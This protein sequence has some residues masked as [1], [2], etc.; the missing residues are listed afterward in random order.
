MKYVMINNCFP[1]IFHESVQ[2]ELMKRLEHDNFKITSAG[3][4][5]E[6]TLECFG[7]S[8]LKIGIAELDT[9]FVKKLLGVK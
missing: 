9:L 5:Q 8:F 3:F 4:I 1:I 2:H 6:G 7:S